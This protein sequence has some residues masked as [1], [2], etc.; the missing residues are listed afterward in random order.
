MTLEQAFE[1]A[2]ELISSATE[3]ALRYLKTGAQVF[4]NQI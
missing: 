3:Q 2:P 1:N 4:K